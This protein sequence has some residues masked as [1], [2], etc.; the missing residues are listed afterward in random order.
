MK[1][2]LIHYQ[3]YKYYFILYI[4]NHLQN[5]NYLLYFYTFQKK[6][7]ILFFTIL[8]KLLWNSMYLTIF[9]LLILQLKT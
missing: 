3:N 8:N 4:L 5:I 9:I 1:L 7:K 2:F 6:L